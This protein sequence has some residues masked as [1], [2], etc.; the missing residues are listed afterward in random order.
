MDA[1]HHK[2]MSSLFKHF[3]RDCPRPTAVSGIYQQPARLG[4]AFRN[5]RKIVIIFLSIS[6]IMCF[7][8]SKESSH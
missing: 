1:N 7:G 8:C 3:S 6:L 4:Q 5:L 2:L